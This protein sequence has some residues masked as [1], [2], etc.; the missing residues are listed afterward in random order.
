[1]V[2]SG[3]R[4]SVA[5]AATSDGRSVNDVKCAVLPHVHYPQ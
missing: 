3:V 5:G 2:V 4:G 1:M